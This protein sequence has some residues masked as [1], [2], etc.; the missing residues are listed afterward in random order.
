MTIEQLAELVQDMRNAQREYFR[1]RGGP[2][3]ERSNAPNQRAG[4]KGAS[5]GKRLNTGSVALGC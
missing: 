4:G 2:A 5:T 3:L 1:T